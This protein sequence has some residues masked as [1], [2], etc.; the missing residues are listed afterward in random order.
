M[1]EQLTWAA[2]INDIQ[3]LMNRYIINVH[4][5]D[6]MSSY[7]ELMAND[8]PDLEFEYME[9]GAYTGAEHVKQYMQ[10]LHNYMQ[11]PQDKLGYMCLNHCMTPNII[12]NDK[13][14]RAIGHW[15]VFSPWAQPATPF[16]CDKRKLTAMWFTGK[17]ENEFIKIDGEWKILKIHLIA[18][19]RSP[20]ELGWVRQADAMRIKIMDGL[21][22]DKA[23]RTYAY[24][25]DAVYSSNNI[26]NWGPFLPDD[27]E[28]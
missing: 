22:P 2:D 3:Q 10:A 28:F 5:M 25:P 8:N 13:G 11:S 19:T 15:S 18:Y 24:H 14:D 26:F 4:R 1:K 12:I 27:T 20:Y 16:P 23:P 7:H 21:T 9:S 17:Y 6:Y